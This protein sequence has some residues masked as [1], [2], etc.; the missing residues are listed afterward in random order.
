MN[1]DPTTTISLAY[2][3]EFSDDGKQPVQTEPE[4]VILPPATQDTAGAPAP[5]SSPAPLP[6]P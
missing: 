6:Q 1:P 4:V 3:V 5:A 2:L